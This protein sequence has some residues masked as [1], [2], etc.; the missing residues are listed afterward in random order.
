M[1]CNMNTK[2]LIG[3]SMIALLV[4]ALSVGMAAAADI[5]P[6]D[7]SGVTKIQFEDNE[8]VYA[9]G[10]GP[11]STTCYVYVMD[12]RIVWNDN[13]SLAGYRERV[14]VVIDNTGMNFN[15]SPTMIWPA[16]ETVVGPYD[17]VIDTG[18]DGFFNSSVDDVENCRVTGFTVVPEFTT[19]AIPMIALLGLVLY[20]RRKK[21]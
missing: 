8:D 3:T 20:M 14:T 4:V 17:L 6:S 2:N 9:V 5:G 13:D 18:M 10:Q 15:P 19:I 1:R 11:A 16:E 12:N 7:A 21:D